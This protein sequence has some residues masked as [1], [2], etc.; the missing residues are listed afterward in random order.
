M[1]SRLRFGL[2]L[3]AYQV[4]IE[5][6]DELLV[7]Q[8]ILGPRMPSVLLENRRQIPSLQLAQAA[9]Y[10]PGAVTAEVAHHEE[11]VI[12]QFEEHVQALEHR[13]LGN[14]LPRRVLAHFLP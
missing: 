1:H 9:D 3:F 2:G 8:S 5:E 6:L 7:D 11:R 14:C 10:R 4:G 12:V 13:L